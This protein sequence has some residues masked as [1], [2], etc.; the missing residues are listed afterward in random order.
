M[1]DPRGVHPFRVEEPLLWLLSQFNVVPSKGWRMTVSS[2]R[3]IYTDCRPGQGLRGS[4]RAAV[5]GALSDR[6]S[7]AE[8]LVKDHLLYEPPSRWMRDRRP[9]EDYPRSFAHLSAAGYFAT[10]TGLYLG[11]EANGVRE[12]N[13]LTHAIVT[14]DPDAYGGR[15]RPS[16]SAP[17]F[18]SRPAGRHHPVGAGDGQPGAGAVLRRPGPSSSSS[19][20]PTGRPCCPPW[21][22]ALQPGRRVGR[23]GCCSSRRRPQVV[24][25]WLV[26]ATLLLPQRQA[27]RVGFKV[28][29]TNPAYA[30][31]QVLAVH[32]GWQSPATSIDNDLGYAVFDLAAN[33]WTPVEPSPTARLWVELFGRE[34]PYDVIDAVEVAAASGM[35]SA[36]A[37]TVALA[38]ILRR[39]PADDEATAV[40]SWLNRGPDPLVDTY[41]GVVAD[42]MLDAAEQWPAALLLKL[43]EA[44]GRSGS[45]ERMLRARLALI[46]AEAHQARTTSHVEPGRPAP[47]PGWS[48]DHQARAEQ[49]VAAALGGATGTG[50]DAVL[51]VAHRFGLAVS[52]AGMQAQARAFVR[53]WADNPNRPYDPRCWSCRPEL[54]DLLR[55]EL[56]RRLTEQPGLSEQI[57]DAWW[58]RL[59]AGAGQVADPVED[60]VVSAAMAFGDPEQRGAIVDTVL[61]AGVDTP[62]GHRAAVLWRRAVPTFEEVELLA[63]HVPAGFLLAPHTFLALAGRLIHDG[64]NVADLEICHE[65]VRRKLWRPDP[66]LAKLVDDDRAVAMLSEGLQRSGGPP[67]SLIVRLRDLWPGLVDLRAALLLDSLLRTY[68]A[69]VVLPVLTVAPQLTLSLAQRLMA[70]LRRT[71]LREHALM[72]FFLTRPDQLH[73]AVA[74]E[75][76]PRWCEELHARVRQWAMRVVEPELKLA[77][78][79]IDRLGPGW[80]GPW[81]DLL[82]ETRRGGFRG[83]MRRFGRS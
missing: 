72:A 15:A 4:G 2:T 19:T 21:C 35:P 83:R 76:S 24:L 36:V 58:R 17:P 28:F 3:S 38:A 10:A 70:E 69:H 63:V 66:P 52:L 45:P 46:R 7:A 59:A 12:G 79:Q 23:R 65:L 49:V 32:P 29:T 48:A 16:C 74:A 13:Q 27:L 68:P 62:I 26:A 30:T 73:P 60:A 64:P 75:L 78:E 44:A 18:W 56:N 47:P 25:R 51:R 9:V 14:T 39:R 5:P 67:A 33:T 22:S 34:D 42:L 55:D 53:D 71:G 11:R 1:V 54:E 81:R 61:A 40:I 6:A 41:G 20:T 80:A 50:F 37:P 8:G 82:R 43:D 31:Q 57:G 77:T